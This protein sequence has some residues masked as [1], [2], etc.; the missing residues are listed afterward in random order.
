MKVVVYSTEHCPK[1]NRL[2]DY[3]TSKGIPFTVRDMQ[4]KK[5]RSILLS[6]NV[7]TRNAPVLDA[8]GTYLTSED[9]FDIDGLNTR[10]IDREIGPW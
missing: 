2:K 10:L 8:D 7:F 4:D 6:M 1:C 3:L 5:N 9:L